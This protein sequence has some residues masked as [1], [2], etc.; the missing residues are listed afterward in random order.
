[1]PDA[2]AIHQGNVSGPGAGAGQVKNQPVL[3]GT[4]SLDESHLAHYSQ[5]AWQCNTGEG[6]SYVNVGDAGKTGS[7]ALAL[8]ANVICRVQNNAD[9]SSYTIAKSSN[10]TGQVMPDEEITY[11]LTAKWSGGVKL[12]NTVVRDDLTDVLDDA[13]LVGA[14]PAGAVLDT[15]SEPG[16]TFL[17]WTIPLLEDTDADR[18]QTLSYKVKVNHDA[19]GADLRNVVT[20]VSENGGCEEGNTCKTDHPTPDK[21]KLTLVKNVTNGLGGTAKSTDWTL[22]ATPGAGVDDAQA[23]V[24]GKGGFQA[25]SV[26]PG[27]Y[28]LS[29]SDGVDGYSAGD[30]TCD[31]AEGALTKVELEPGDD[32]TCEIT[33]T[34]DAVWKVGKSNSAGDGAT[35]QPGD[36]ITYTLTATHV[37]G[38]KPTGIVITDDLS[39]LTPYIDAFD[40]AQLPAAASRTGDKLVW[41]VPAFQ[42]DETVQTL[43]YTV[44]VKASAIGVTLKNAITAPGSNCPPPDTFVPLALS[45]DACTT[46][47]PTP[48][49]TLSKSSDPATGTQVAPSST[50]T[51]T[52]HTKNTSDA[53]L[54]DATVV[55][56]LSGVLNNATLNP[57]ASDSGLTLDGTTLTW[58]LPTLNPGEEATT[59]YSVTMTIP[60]N[61][62]G[63][64][65]NVAAPVQPT[66]HCVAED[67]CTTTHVQNPAPLPP[68]T[69]PLTPPVVLPPAPPSQVAPP[70]ALPNTGGPRLVYLPSGIGLLLL[71]IGLMLAGR[72]REVE[73]PAVS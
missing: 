16:K 39:Q 56:D 43:T 47:N 41:K 28:G 73:E 38:V 55:D 68:V 59:S 67:A 25:T 42:G 72:R 18:A 48:E 33:N 29:E 8:D 13:T 52:L 10:K 35:V 66:G 11:T 53:V 20:P 32:V 27:S 26:W 9:A 21:P 3:P 1:M 34:Q 57:L 17:V 12:T 15:I 69:P 64:I 40:D 58:A 63:M 6:G 22:K 46:S 45:E 5:G 49:W 23:A 70:A 4:Y 30:W 60:A 71:G 50:I 7:I 31:N 62:G 65:V 51:Y 14:L 61:S 2:G 19:W 24:S 36:S 54:K 37:A 44:K